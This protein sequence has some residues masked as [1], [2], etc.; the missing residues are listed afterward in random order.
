M[1]PS[2]PKHILI[3]SSEFPPNVGG[4]GNHAFH[5]ARYLS[6]E[7]YTVS[8]VADVIDVTPADLEAFKKNISF[9]FYPVKR[10]GFVP[11]TYA[12]RI[13]KAVAHA[14]KTDV[15][16][17]SGKFSLWLI[18]II[19]RFYPGKKCVAV[20]HGTELQLPQQKAK[21]LT[22]KSLKLFDII[23][24]VSHFTKNLL[25]DSI[26]NHSKVFV[27]PNGIDVDEFEQYH[28]SKTIQQNDALQLITIGSQSE[29]KGQE[30]VIRA[31]PEILHFFSKAHYHVV[32]KPVIQQHL[33]SIVN[34][35]GI[36][37]KISFCGAV[38][39]EK[40]LQLLQEAH[41]KL[42]LS[43]NANDGDVEGFGIA[44]LEA[45]ALGVPAIG[46]KDSGLADAIANYR[47]GILVNP[48][49]TE[50]VTNAVKEIVRNYNAYSENAR[51]WA[52]E[53][54]WNILIK[55]YIRLIE[56]L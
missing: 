38:S 31:M 22:E 27:I 37:K 48:K 39:R 26:K 51:Q 8:V 6:K 16:I 52:Q 9:N 41:I 4:I 44:V 42:M 25:P 40:L 18:R 17:C 24:A 35:L 45:N 43:N 3:I 46:S 36:E 20:V 29:R 23:I 56:L 33:T 47:T 11:Y 15:I 19:K 28:Q 13:L 1:R 49:N 21:E 32:G 34:K 55:E 54:D 12:L 14:Q 10:Y 5:I 7:N 2:S 50:E 30:N 53:H